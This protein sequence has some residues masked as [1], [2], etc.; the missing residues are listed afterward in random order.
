MNP[1]GFRFQRRL[2]LGKGLGLN[3]SKSGIGSSFRGRYGSIG[4]TGLSIRSGIPGLTFRQGW[5]K[6]GQG[7]IV[8]LAVMAI[9]TVTAVLTIMVFR[10]IVILACAL[11]AGAR[12]CALTASDYLEYRRMGAQDFTEQVPRLPNTTV[13][14]PGDRTLGE[15][16]RGSKSGNG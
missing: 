1:M 5:G 3:V 6:G 2:N 13:V 14:E 9:V 16:I 7:A 8:A 11:W 4:S 10:A 12:W 15:I